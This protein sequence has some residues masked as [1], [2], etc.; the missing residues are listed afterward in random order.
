MGRRGKSRAC[1]HC[2][3]PLRPNQLICPECGRRQRHGARGWIRPL[4]IT[5]AVMT[6]LALVLIAALWLSQG[7]DRNR[8]AATVDQV[9]TPGEVLA[10]TSTAVPSSTPRST[11]TPVSTP[12]SSSTP[13]ATGTPT[14]S[15][16]PP[17]THTPTSTTTRTPTPSQTP[18]PT[19]TPTSTATRT[20]VPTG[21][22]TSTTTRTPTPSRTPVP[23]GT[24]ISTATRTSTPS[25]TP[26]P[27]DSPGPTPSATL[28]PTNT[29]TSLPSP[30]LTS[31][32]SAASTPFIHVV[33]V[34]D[35][36][37]DIAAAYGTTVD[38]IMEANGLTSTR[39]SVGQRL[40]IPLVT[41][42]PAPT[43]PETATV[44]PT[45]P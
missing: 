15:R 34:G 29:P 1:A 25:Q 8:P 9:S 32:P 30:A 27:T 36:L 3:T 19:G 28:T 11:D 12:T 40:I 33:Q 7:Q 6:G 21:T 44:T 39:L 13:T 22:P 4:L 18:A 31:T 2:D 16:T 43:S 45:Q 38:A 24:P 10:A 41:A 14:P 37:Y 23:T 5:L 26:A 42:T 35:T 17:P 20:P